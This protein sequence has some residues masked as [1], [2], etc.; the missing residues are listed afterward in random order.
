V[1]AFENDMFNKVGQAM[2][3]HKFVPC[4]GVDGN[5]ATH[6]LGGN[7]LMSYANTVRQLKFQ[8]V[9]STKVYI[10]IFFRSPFGIIKK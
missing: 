10:L 6:N 1:C 7:V 5:A 4:S 9:H 3:A 8:N 2:L